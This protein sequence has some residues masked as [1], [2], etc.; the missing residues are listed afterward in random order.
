M[1]DPRDVIIRPVV[2]ERSTILADDSG[3]YTFIVNRDAN[4][5]EIKNAVQSLFDVKVRDVRTANFRGKIRRVGRSVGKKPSFK[6]AVVT[7]AEGER[8]DVYEGI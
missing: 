1:R 3:K 6:K 7:L 2:T 4:K 5:I 8:I